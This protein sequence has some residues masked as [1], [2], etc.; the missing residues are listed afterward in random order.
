MLPPLIAENRFAVVDCETT[1]VN[2]HRDEVI[3]IAIIQIDHGRPRF[4]TTCYVQPTRIIAEHAMDK[5][6]ITWDVLQHAP[7]FGDVADEI[8]SF[9]GNRTLLGYQVDRFDCVFLRRQLAE[10]GRSFNTDALDVLKYERKFGGKG[11]HNLVAAA[12]RWEV[13][14]LRAHDAFDD[15]RMTWNVFLQL[16]SRHPELGSAPL[17]EVL[18]LRAAAPLED[19]AI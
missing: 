5:H 6:G 12:E 7:R 19:V 13:P 16:A 9:I 8:L 17:H 2:I 3:Q 18:T 14:I 4:R 1:G 11:K 10:S 15:C